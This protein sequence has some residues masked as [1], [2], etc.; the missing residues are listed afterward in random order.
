[1]SPKKT[2]PA[3]PTSFVGRETELSLLRRS[4]AEGGRLVTLL[5]PPGIGKSRLALR[6]AE[7]SALLREPSG[8]IFVCDLVDAST[9]DDLCAA[10][11]RSIDVVVGSEARGGDRVAELGVRLTALG[12]ALV[13]LDNFERLV[14]VGPETLGRWMRLSGKTRF[15]VTSRERLRL[16]G[17]IIYEI[18]PLA[19]PEGD[20]DLMSFEAVQL[21]VERARAVRPSFAVSPENAA[22]VAEIV[23]QLDGIPL[24]VEL[25]ASRMAVLS[26]AKL[27]ERM[28][29][30]LE[31][32]SAGLRNATARQRTLRDAIDASY[33]L[34]EPP[35]Q[36][37]LAQ[38][39]AFRGGFG[40]EAAEA[41]VDLSAFPGAPPLLDVIES[42]AGKSLIFARTL[43]G[44]PDEVRFGL[45]LSIRDYAE[46]RL[47]E[48]GG[49][50]AV[51]LRHAA[52]FLEVGRR[53]SDGVEGPDGASL[54]RRLGLDRENLIAV[55]RRLLSP[56]PGLSADPEGAL[57]AALALEPVLVR[58]GPVSMLYS[59]LDEAL[60]ASVEIE[61]PLRL[62]GLLSLANAL[63]LLGRIDE[64]R[65]GFEA[66]AI[67]ARDLRD[68]RMSGI[69]E[70]ALGSVLREQG[71]LREAERTL[72][73]AIKLLT[74]CGESR[75]LGRAKN[76]L[77]HMR[78]VMG[79]I[80]GARGL[81][82]EARRI[83]VQEG[84]RELTTMALLSLA[85]NAVI[86]GDL[87]EAAV[88]LEDAR[89]SAPHLSWPMFEA[90]YLRTLGNLRQEQGRLAEAQASMQAS[91][92]LER[93][94]GNVRVEGYSLGH[95]GTICAEMGD[96]VQARAA[97][98][99]ATSLLGESGDIRGMALFTAALAAV[100]ARLGHVAEAELL[101]VSVGT[102]PQ[103]PLDVVL[104]TA[105]D[106]YAAFL[107]LARAARTDGAEARASLL[108]EVKATV[109]RVK[110]PGWSDEGASSSR[111]DR[112]L[113]TPLERS[114][115]V[116]VA[117]RLLER[118]FG[119]MVRSGEAPPAEAEVAPVT[120]PKAQAAR[121]AE[122]VLVVSPDARWCRLPDG[123]EV[124]FSKGRALRLML[125]RLFEE[126]LRA[127]GR[128]LSID[129]LFASGWPGEK[130]SSEAVENRVYVGISRLRKLG[131]KGLLMSR[132]D[133]FLL[134]PAVPSYCAEKPL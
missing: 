81:H 88:Y 100:R 115:H 55:H 3:Q 92:S 27:L 105:V 21:F 25:G 77:G 58:W 15:L 89:A 86:G 42:L 68:R 132:D 12:D 114:L 18:G 6:L 73:G 106:I 104:S 93:E 10:L 127:P 119:E 52:H 23:R 70:A 108:G 40:L 118:A 79:D 124:E 48:Q 31:I 5:G 82:E 134:D 39:S 49:A 29:R 34:L 35:E 4:F 46:S 60:G 113:G 133:G 112:S 36:S 22:A 131:F 97:L 45:Y 62:R 50:R 1:M 98:E 37:A 99:R 19:L 125:L 103:G 94:L 101:V 13:V 78:T 30:R 116:R 74:A 102:A 96:F 41:V 90:G 129:D 51:H 56:G 95:L 65:P 126:R 8:G 38:L 76:A 71:R 43:E 75:W 66:A 53:L 20:R 2:L 110:G 84:D 44:Y 11:S 85:M 14:G 72:E 28:P 91:L 117:L 67:L 33:R 122:R 54:V 63:R 128:A 47:D 24:A 123:A 130:A 87:D 32:L 57:R 120:A 7:M 61:P 64:S 9:A 109:A 107:P 111:G 69:A 121:P 26:P 83:F 80:A 59:M 17:E 16:A